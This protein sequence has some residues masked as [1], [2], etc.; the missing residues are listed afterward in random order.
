MS[1]VPF[2]CVEC[3]A[4]FHELDGGICGVC[5]RLLCRRHLTVRTDGATCRACARADLDERRKI[6]EESQSRRLS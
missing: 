2:T 1:I 6:T 4:R 3:G 5:A